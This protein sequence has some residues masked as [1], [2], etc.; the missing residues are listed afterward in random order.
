MVEWTGE[1]V[2]H[3]IDGRRNDLTDGAPVIIFGSCFGLGTA[4][5][6]DWLDLTVDDW[7]LPDSSSD[8]VSTRLMSSK[9]SN[10]MGSASLIRGSESAVPSNPLEC[11]CLVSATS[12]VLASVKTGAPSGESDWPWI[13]SRG[14]LAGEA[15]PECSRKLVS[16]ASSK[17]SCTVGTGVSNVSRDR[18]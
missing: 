3:G 13:K 2:D 6:D 9:V 18:Y 17:V 7:D 1:A 5:L 15:S 12:F 10:E 16:G 11:F 8:P 4:S 14:D